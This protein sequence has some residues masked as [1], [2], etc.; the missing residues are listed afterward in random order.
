MVEHGASLANLSELGRMLHRVR[1]ATPSSPTRV[2]QLL[3]YCRGSTRLGTWGRTTGGRLGAPRSR[4][5]GRSEFRSEMGARG[6]D[7]NK[8][9]RRRR[10]SQGSQFV[11]SRAG[12]WHQVS[13]QIRDLSAHFG[14]TLWTTLAPDFGPLP[15]DLTDRPPLETPGAEPPKT[16]PKQLCPRVTPPMC[17]A[18]RCL[19][20][21]VPS[22]TRSQAD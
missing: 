9:R 2:H 14:A 22:Q 11:G 5:E 7:L 17:Q 3:G 19:H 1:V 8:N 6:S 4:S 13:F 21:I 12:L 20:C 16:S 15:G 18:R 10:F